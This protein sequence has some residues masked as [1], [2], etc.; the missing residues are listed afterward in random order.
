VIRS[1]RNMKRLL[2]LLT[3]IL[4]L[5]YAPALEAK[6]G[7]SAGRVSAPRLAK[8]KGSKVKRAK[9]SK[10]SK[11]SMVPGSNDGTYSRGSGSSHK[12]GKYKNPKTGGKYR[13]RQ[14]GAPR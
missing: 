1:L 12:G 4:A 6:G 13:N 9:A 8:A 3:T 2:L 10:A 5:A 14:A 11:K 7:K